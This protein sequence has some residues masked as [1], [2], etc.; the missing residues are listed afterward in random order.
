MLDPFEGVTTEEVVR[1]ACV[2]DE[3][4]ARYDWICPYCDELFTRDG[5]LFVHLEGGS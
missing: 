3:V 1:R 5:D 2:Y 4:A